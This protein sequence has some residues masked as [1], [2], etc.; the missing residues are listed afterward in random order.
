[1][2]IES[3]F[4]EGKNLWMLEHLDQFGKFNRIVFGSVIRVPATNAID[5]FMPF[6]KLQHD[7]PVVGFTPNDD[8]S[9]DT[10]GKSI[11]HDL[12]RI[13]KVLRILD[14]AVSIDQHG[15]E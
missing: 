15:F 9:L 14:M 7:S 3:N 13:V 2:V 11:R 4:S 12:I 10:C 5:I 1:M 8:D 6:D